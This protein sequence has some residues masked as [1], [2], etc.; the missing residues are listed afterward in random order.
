VI[1]NTPSQVLATAKQLKAQPSDGPA[2]NQLERVGL[3]EALRGM[4]LLVEDPETEIPQ[5]SKEWEALE[6]MIRLGLSKDLSVT[7]EPEPE[8]QVTE[9]LEFHPV[10]LPGG[11]FAQAEQPNAGKL[12]KDGTILWLDNIT[13]KDLHVLGLFQPGT[14]DSLSNKVIIC[15]NQP[16]GQKGVGPVWGAR[17]YNAQGIIENLTIWRAGDWNDLREGH[18]LYINTA[19]ELILRNVVAKQCGAQAIQI[20]FRATE[21]LGLT[22]FVPNPEALIRLVDCQAID[23]GQIGEVHP[24]T[25]KLAHQSRA[26]WPFTFAGTPQKVQLLNCRV[27]CD[28]PQPF[29]SPQGVPYKSRGAVVAW[30]GAEKWAPKWL[31]VQGL[32][33]FLVQ[34]DR[35][36][37]RAEGVEMVILDDY[38]VEQAGSLRQPDLA[39]VDDCGQVIVRDCP[40]D[41]LVRRYPAASPFHN[42]QDIVIPAGKSWQWKD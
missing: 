35:P 37:V 25:G 9:P 10:F 6:S 39:F 11:P 13:S 26:S 27:D 22:G 24:S 20:A 5:L 33:G 31:D 3:A 7:Q 12:L 32:H 15:N 19:G 17:L 40:R 8:V 29:T 16:G 2:F 18:G 23:C 14:D 21:A 30:R 38:D 34:S 41:V 36:I 42:G 4:A 1:K 28:L